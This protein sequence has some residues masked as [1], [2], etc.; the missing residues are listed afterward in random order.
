MVEAMN[1]LR[2]VAGF[3]VTF[4]AYTMAQAPVS[5][6]PRHH[7]TFENSQFRILAVDIPP[8]DTSLEHRH[9]LDVVNVS[10]ANGASTRQQSPGQPWGEVLPSPPLGDAAVAQYA[11]K[12][13]SHRIENVGK[14]AYQLFAVENLHASGWSTTPSVTGLATKMTT[15]A[16]SF[17]VYDVRLGNENMQ[18]SHR[19]A[20]PTIA[21]L[22]SGKIMSEGPDAQAKANAP[23]PV[24]LKQLDRTGQWVLVPSGDT[25]HLVRLGTADAYVVE[26][27][28]R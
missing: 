2:G 4:T 19:H 27:E 6:E 1:A 9:D 23:A 24:G 17:R 5:Q 21:L 15:E 25:H 28:V 20:V 18:T 16:R 14:V 22:I 3:I 11:G 7:V 26:I 12:P 10:M 8:G 13:A